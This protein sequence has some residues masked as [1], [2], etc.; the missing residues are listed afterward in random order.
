MVDLRRGKQSFLFL[1][2]TIRKK[3]SIQRNPRAHF[4]QRWPSPK[5]G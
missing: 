4:V 3:R 2:C 1:G 5:G